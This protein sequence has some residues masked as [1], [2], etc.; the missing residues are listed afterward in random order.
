MKM[1]EI[2]LHVKDRFFVVVLTVFLNERSCVFAVI[3]SE[4][5]TGPSHYLSL[6]N[7]YTQP[8][9]SSSFSSFV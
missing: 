6:Q 3:S 7:N 8:G 1:S 4:I 2:L 5:K 9:F